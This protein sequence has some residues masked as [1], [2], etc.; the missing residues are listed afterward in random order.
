MFWATLVL[1]F[2]L[3]A[4]VA[5]FVVGIMDGARHSDDCAECLLHRFREENP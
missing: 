2:I 5:T 3:G 1:G 4:A